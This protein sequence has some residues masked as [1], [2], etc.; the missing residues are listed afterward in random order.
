M[1]K[2]AFKLTNEFDNYLRECFER[3]EVTL[4]W[5]KKHFKLSLE[6]AKVVH[7]ENLR[8]EDD[9][10]LHN[11]LYELSFMEETPTIGRIIS[12]FEV[13]YLLA[14]HIYDFYMENI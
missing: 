5:I 3:K 8:F 4:K 12:K 9:V 13:S 14:K 1:N 6:E 10:F 11:T 2:L 7:E